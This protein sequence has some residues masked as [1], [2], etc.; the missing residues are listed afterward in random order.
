[1]QITLEPSNAFGVGVFAIIKWHMEASDSFKIQDL[2]CFHFKGNLDS[3]ISSI[4]SDCEITDMVGTNVK[5]TDVKL[6][7]PVDSSF[8]YNYLNKMSRVNCRDTICKK[9]V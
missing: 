2:R 8:K 9:E 6:I 4:I 3:C 5:G 7:I 1:M